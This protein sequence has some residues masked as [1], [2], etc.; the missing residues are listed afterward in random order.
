MG[1]LSLHAARTNT[2]QKRP[3]ESQGRNSR[4]EIAVETGLLAYE[5][6]HEPRPRKLICTGGAI[7]AAALISGCVVWIFTRRHMPSG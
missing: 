1:S 5:S 6:Q 2:S 4:P 7:C 3:G